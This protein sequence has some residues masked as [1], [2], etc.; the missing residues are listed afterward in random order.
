MSL[1][2]HFLMTIITGISNF[3]VLPIIIFFYK[4][5]KF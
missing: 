4:T 1:T 3:A 2:E 5:N